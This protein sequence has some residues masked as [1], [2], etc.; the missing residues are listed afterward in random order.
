M[1]EQHFPDVH[2]SDESVQVPNRWR[3]RFESTHITRGLSR[4]VPLTRSLAAVLVGLMSWLCQLE[5]SV[6]G[7]SLVS[8]I[9]VLPQQ[10]NHGM[11]TWATLDV[12]V[13]HAT[14]VVSVSVPLPPPPVPPVPVPVV[15]VVPHP[16]V[17]VV[18]HPVVPV[19]PV[20]P[21]PAPVVPY[22]APVGPL[23]PQ[24]A[25]GTPHSVPVVPY[26][27]PAPPAP[28]WEFPRPAPVVP[29]PTRVFPPPVVVL[30]QVPNLVGD[31]LVTGEQVLIQNGLAIGSISR[32]ASNLPAGTIVQTNPRANAAVP[33]GTA[34]NLAVAG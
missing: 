17:P 11:T 30:K 26:P 21:H 15:P 28:T 23:V 29:A 4:G 31:D 24:P 12:V 8:A 13:H 16:V 32:Q 2:P 27:I 5:A 25:P 3:V 20:V 19:V 18:P 9:H 7:A 10:Q 33:T 34:I 1:T 14:A 6:E 22:P